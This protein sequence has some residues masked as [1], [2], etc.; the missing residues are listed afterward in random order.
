M[1]DIKLF[2]EKGIFLKEKIVTKWEPKLK[3]K[4]F[5][6]THKE[7]ITKLY[8]LKAKAQK[9]VLIVNWIIRGRCHYCYSWAD[10][11]KHFSVQSLLGR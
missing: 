11:W 5:Q 7:I 1:T 6:I 2:L 4:I 8:D 10:R 3:L 9:D